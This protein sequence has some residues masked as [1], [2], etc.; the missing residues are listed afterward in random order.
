MAA[1][2]V[3]I[4]PL[5]LGVG[6]RGKI[7]E[8]WS[9]ARAVVATSIACAGLRHE[10]GKNLLVADDAALF[11]RH[12]VSLLRDPVRR[13]SLGNEGRKTAERYYGWETVGH[14]LDSLYQHYMGTLPKES[15]V[16]VAGERSRA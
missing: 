2:A 6:I 10:A 9:M 3:Y 7:L 13:A 14:E 15:L 8:A 1:G 16:S 12:V 11:A 4:V 5:R